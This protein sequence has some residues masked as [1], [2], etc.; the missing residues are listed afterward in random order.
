MAHPNNLMTYLRLAHILLFIIMLI[1]IWAVWRIK[2]F[3]NLD[4]SILTGGGIVVLLFFG[5]GLLFHRIFGI[6][7]K[8]GHCLGLNPYPVYTLY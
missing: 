7:T 1:F 4:A 6:N 8:I 2:L 5:M 3:K